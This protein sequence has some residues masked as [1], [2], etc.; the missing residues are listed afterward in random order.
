MQVMLEAEVIAQQLEQQLE[1]KFNKRRS[2][3]QGMG[4]RKG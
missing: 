4:S 1:D 2:I 3:R